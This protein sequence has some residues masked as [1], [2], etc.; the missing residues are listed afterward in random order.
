M[1]L[2]LTIWLEVTLNLWEIL[3][4][5]CL[6]VFFILATTRI[7]SAFRFRCLNVSFAIYHW[8]IPLIF[9]PAAYYLFYFFGDG[10][11]RF[12]DQII[13]KRLTAL[14]DNLS[15]DFSNIL[16]IFIWTLCF[17]QATIILSALWPI[18]VAICCWRLIKCYI[19]FA[20]TI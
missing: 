8:R 17:M 7:W 12:Y 3:I 16:R 11:D 4:P 9:R 1:P 13:K 20:K 5:S 10:C 15:K 14:E 19:A 2:L 18:I 6:I